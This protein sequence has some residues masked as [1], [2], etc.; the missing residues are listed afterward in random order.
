MSQGIRNIVHEYV[1]SVLTDRQLDE[2]RELLMQASGKHKIPITL[3]VDFAV[4]DDGRANMTTSMSIGMKIPHWDKAVDLTGQ[5]TLW[6]EAPSTTT[7]RKARVSAPP[8][9][10]PPTASQPAAPTIPD[11]ELAQPGL[12]PVIETDDGRLATPVPGSSEERMRAIE[13]QNQAVLEEAEKTGATLTPEARL[14]LK[15]Q[16]TRA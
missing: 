10:E 14:A 11:S 7:A 2:V 5:M 4:D 12:A 6:S 8:P 3:K 9:P 16:A 15:N 1:D 13:A